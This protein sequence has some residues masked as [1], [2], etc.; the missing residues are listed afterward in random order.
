MTD[1]QARERAWRV[2]QRRQ[3]TIYRLITSGTIEEKIYH[4]WGCMCVCVCVCECVPACLRACLQAGVRVWV[5]MC[6]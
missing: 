3:V 6:V 1:V 5:C 2:G 4:R